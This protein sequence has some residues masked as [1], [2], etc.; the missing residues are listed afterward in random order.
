MAT[1]SKTAMATASKTTVATANTTA[2][3]YALPPSSTSTMVT[4]SA[5]AHID[6]A[7]VRRGWRASASLELDRNH[8]Q[9]QGWPIEL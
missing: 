9:S 1:A 8:S 2:E 3:A 7:I 5:P 6:F 4:A